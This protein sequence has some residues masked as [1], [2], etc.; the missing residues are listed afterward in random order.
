VAE[1]IA[2]G[3]PTVTSNATS[4]PEI[5]AWPASTFD[6]ARPE[7]MAAV[8]GRALTDE[9]F[10][11]ELRRVGDQAASRWTWD[12]V[13]D[14][15][16]TAVDGLSRS[17]TSSR[18]PR[19]LRIALAS[20]FFPVP[21]GVAN[22]SG[23]LLDALAERC[24]LDLLVEAGSDG[25]ALAGRARRVLPVTRLGV[26]AD[27]SA[28]DALLYAVGNSVFHHL[29]HDAAL[30]HPGILWLHDIR[31]QGLVTTWARARFGARWPTV[32][33]EMIE[34]QYGPRVPRRD[35][36]WGL[37]D[38]ELYGRLTAYDAYLTRHLVAG[39]RGVLLHS[40]GARRLLELD[41]PAGS[42]T[43]PAIVVPVTVPR[44]PA[45]SRERSPRPLVVSM[46]IV[47]SVK[48]P[49][50]LIRAAA[51]VD[52]P[53]DVALVG[54]ISDGYRAELERLATAVGLR[55]ELMLPGAVDHDEYWTW[56]DRAWGAVQ[57]RRTW[58]GETSG[59]V[60]D[61]V[62][63][64]VPVAT[65]LPS[66]GEMVATGAAT[67]LPMPVRVAD[68]AEW[69]TSV[70]AGTTAAEQRECQQRYTDAHGPGDV[71]DAILDAIGRLIAGPDR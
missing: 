43:P 21:S 22:Y 33:D 56:L 61:A 50:T 24:D 8:M 10:R 40:E 47:A 25:R 35:D 19:R 5:L 4:V 16:L 57:L 20:P 29:T 55:G 11:A 37:P 6:P 2:C 34:S 65:N 67:P 23:L 69:L 71:A 66:A 63:S 30:R 70:V 53:L 27:P 60:N 44:R 28:Y 17:E 7:D 49:E 18:R 52:G 26:T 32:V 58:N 54:E 48:D 12:A 3:C 36:W 45:G 14:R 62:A 42:T 39:S 15:T 13:A 31:L 68:V 64:G 9:Q 1:A 46:G 51:L 41:Q 38:H 59:A